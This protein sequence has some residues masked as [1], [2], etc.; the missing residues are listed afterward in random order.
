ML[1]SIRR[2]GFVEAAAK[3]KESSARE[4]ARAELADARKALSDTG[5][6]VSGLWISFI[7]FGLYLTVTAGGITHR[8]LFLEAPVSLPIVGTAL[9]LVAFFWVAP[10]LFI[11]G[12]AHMLLHLTVLAERAR[13]YVHL[14]DAVIPGPEKRARSD[15]QLPSHILIEF[16]VAPRDNSRRAIGAVVRFVAWF[17]VVLAPVALLLLFQVS[18]LPYQDAMTTWMHRGFLLVD[19]IILLVFWPKVL[20]GVTSATTI[21]FRRVLA[22]SSGSIAAALFSFGIATFPGEAHH[23]NAASRT[24][25][26]AVWQVSGRPLFFNEVNPVTGRHMGWLTNALVLPDE[27]LVDVE[28]VRRIAAHEQILPRTWGQRSLTQPR[29]RSFVE[30]NFERADLRMADFRGAN[31]DGARLTNANLQEASLDW[32]RLRGAN[33]DSTQLQGASLMFAQLQGSRMERARLRGALLDLA[34]LQGVS[35]DFADL[36]GA[37]LFGAQLEGASLFWAHLAGARLDAVQFRAASLDFAALQG[38]SLN[39]ARL[40]GASLGNAQLQ[41]ASLEFAELLGTSLQGAQFQGALLRRAFVWRANAP[42]PDAFTDVESEG[43]DWA[44][45]G[46]VASPSGETG[47]KVFDARQYAALM[48]E[49]LSGMGNG[50]A[51]AALMER[52]AVLDPGAPDPEGTTDED[53]W[54]AV[55]ESYDPGRH[56]DFI[57]A[58]ACADENAPHVAESLLREH[59]LIHNAASPGNAAA[60]RILGRLEAGTCPGAAGISDDAGR[61]LRDRAKWPG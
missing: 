58:L 8:Q 38:A 26:F 46:W 24:L 54:K 2:G 36:Q 55:E 19:L 4:E 17:T 35:L 39:H 13:H 34:Q 49:V 37:S 25:Q 60:R 52:L 53:F 6:F 23:D 28:L 45:V 50:A 41:G 33:L 44:H 27:P 31:L 32:A 10:V 3:K 30:A 42:D 11:I 48:A 57:A 61:R 9:P 5:K 40:H 51:P 43:L 22:L 20:S 12:H 47:K 29:G 16:L 21:P 18:F 7:L 14:A 56:A 15:A 59:G 1:R